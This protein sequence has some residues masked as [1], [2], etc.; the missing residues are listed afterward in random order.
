MRCIS[1]QSLFPFF[2]RTGSSLLRTDFLQLVQQRL[3]F[4]AVCSFLIVV[5]SLSLQSSGSR[6]QG[7]AIM[8]HGLSCPITCGIFLILVSCIGRQILDHWTTREVLLVVLIC[9]PLIICNV[10]HLFIGLLDICVSLEKSLFKSFA[11]CKIK[12]FDFFFFFFCY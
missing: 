9:T 5:A 4:A 10:E 3:L 1:L 7:S 6:H 8:A 2:G 12:L 11:H